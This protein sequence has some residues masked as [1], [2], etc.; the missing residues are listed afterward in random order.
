MSTRATSDEAWISQAA[1]TRRVGRVYAALVLVWL[2]ILAWQ[3]AANRALLLSHLLVLVSWIALTAIVNLVPIRGWQSA[4]FAADDPVCLAIA[5][6]FPPG[7]CAL[8]TFLGAVD[9]RELKGQTTVAKALWNRSHVSIGWLLGSSVAHAVANSPDTSPA[10][11]PIAF[12]AFGVSTLS[13]YAV[14][15]PA[16]AFERGYSLRYVIRHMKVGTLTDFALAFAAWAVLG[17]M[18]SVLYE[19]SG[20]WALPF[21]VAPTLMGRQILRRSQMFVEADRAFKISQTAFLQLTHQVDQERNDERRLVAG[22]LHDEVLQALFKVSLMSH[23]I[24]RGLSPDNISIIRDDLDELQSAADTSVEALRGI[25]TDLRRSNL[26]RGG[27]S[28]ALTRIVSIASRQATIQIA[29]S[30]KPVTAEGLEQLVLYQIA[31][32]ALNNALLHSRAREVRV[33]LDS[34]EDS[35][36]LAIQDNGIGFDPYEERAGHFGVALMQERAQSIGASLFLDSS[37]G[38]GCKVT[39]LLARKRES[40]RA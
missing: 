14:V 6:A 26:G 3:V 11:L 38:D 23:V 40:T 24:R 36:R 31:R 39:V 18:L 15:V 25:I 21:F 13:N 19:I 1:R 20:A 37:L 12:L 34:D 17:A 27:L 7:I 22:E 2:L 8:V 16:I 33:E 30:I 32:E 5:L 29:A 4:P 9:P 10:V 35:I 28:S